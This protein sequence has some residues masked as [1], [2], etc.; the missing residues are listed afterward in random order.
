MKALIQIGKGISS[1]VFKAVGHLSGQ[2]RPVAVINNGSSN[3]DE[4]DFQNRLAAYGFGD[5]KPTVG[6]TSW[7]RELL[8]PNA[9]PLCVFGQQGLLQKTLRRVRGNIYWV[10]EQLNPEAGWEW[11]NMALDQFKMR[12]RAIPDTRTK[13]NS[14][15]TNL[16][17]SS[18][19]RC[20]IFGTGPSLSR[21][22]ERDWSNGI[23]VVCNTIVRDKQLWNHINPHFVV[24]GDGIYHFG[25]TE[26]AKAFRRDLA[27]RLKETDTYFLLP[28]RFYPMVV[29]ELSESLERI[30][31]VPVA[32][33]SEIGDCLTRDYRLPGLPNVLNMLLLPLGCSLSKTVGLWGFDGRA[34][35]DSLFW[36]NSSKQSY[37]ELMDGL[38]AAHPAFFEA[39]VPKEDPGRYVKAVHGDLLEQVLSSA[40]ARGWSFRMLHDSWTPTLQRRRGDF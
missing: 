20:Y 30:L 14:I 35:S 10:D 25:Y 16:R 27:A 34:P 40:E 4:E 26:H 28:D 6:Y 39:Q 31:P 9:T 2:N 21:A 37:P 22:I 32:A 36:A 1:G 19:D 13:F 17:D 38:R 15:A 8:L 12:G 18:F 3:M 23:R 29:E 11:C 33:T 7:A 24:A 5:L